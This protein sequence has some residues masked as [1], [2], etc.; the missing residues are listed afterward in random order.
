[1]GSLLKVIAVLLLDL[2]LVIPFIPLILMTLLSTGLAV[3]KSPVFIVENYPLSV[4]E[5]MV[6]SS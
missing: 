5:S 1:M 4:L 2:S 3:L 6:A